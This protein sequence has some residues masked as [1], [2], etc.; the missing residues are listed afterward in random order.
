MAAAEDFAAALSAASTAVSASDWSAARTQVLL[1]RIAL[2]Q[3]PNAGADGVSVS[4][5]SDL[6]A[7]ERQIDGMSARG[8]R[9]VHADHEFAS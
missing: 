3:L 6:D 1:A 8:R 9:S 5:R 2:A 4:W 7:I